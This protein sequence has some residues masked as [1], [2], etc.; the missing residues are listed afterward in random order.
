MGHTS[1]LQYKHSEKCTLYFFP[2]WEA[3]YYFHFIVFN[4]IENGQF[5]I[6]LQ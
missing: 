5:H 2:S 4:V 1:Q 3:H 6:P